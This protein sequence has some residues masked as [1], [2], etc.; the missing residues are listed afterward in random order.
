MMLLPFW[1]LL[2]LELMGMSL[3][4]PEQWLMVESFQSH[5]MKTLA[6]A[7]SVGFNKNEL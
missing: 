5:Q 3:S 7:E 2:K 4:F 1:G 6:Q